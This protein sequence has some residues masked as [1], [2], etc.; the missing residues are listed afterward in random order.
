[1]YGDLMIVYQEPQKAIRAIYFDNEGHVIN[2]TAQFSQNKDT[3][4]F[5]SDLVPDTPRFRL[6]YIN[7]GI[8]S[9]KIVFEMT[10]PGKPE[11]FFPYLEG[12]AHKRK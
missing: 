1:M 11:K 12:S 10:M 2:Y 6:T 4:T 3:L 9:V 8:D 5:R 7:I